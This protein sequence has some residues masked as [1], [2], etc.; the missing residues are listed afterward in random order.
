MLGSQNYPLEKRLEHIAGIKQLK[1]ICCLEINTYIFIYMDV[2]INTTYLGGGFK[3]FYFQPDP[4]ENDRL[5]LWLM[6]FKW[7]ETTNYRYYIFFVPSKLSLVWKVTFLNWKFQSNKIHITKN[8]PTSWRQKIRR[9]ILVHFGSL[10]HIGC[11]GCCPFLYA[12]VP[13]LGVLI[14]RPSS[15]TAGPRVPV[16]LHPWRSRDV[17]CR[18]HL[19]LQHHSP[20]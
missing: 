13:N 7:V 4:W 18:S 20:Q 19:L 17:G 12:G 14:L 2:Y 15:A 16:C 6:F 1:Y 11:M 3:Y 9:A 10:V 8:V 5:W